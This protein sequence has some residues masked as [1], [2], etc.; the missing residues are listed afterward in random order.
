MAQVHPGALS[1]MLDML[2]QPRLAAIMRATGDVQ[3]Q[4]GIVERDHRR[5]PVTRIGQPIEQLLIRHRIMIDGTKIGHA[6]AGI[7]Q[8]Q[9]QMRARAIICRHDPHRAAQF[10]REHHTV[11]R[12]GVPRPSPAIRRQIGEPQREEPPLPGTSLGHDSTPLAMNDRHCR[13][14]GAKD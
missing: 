4:P 3:R 10:L 8:R 12:C 11:S 2:H 7:G 14:A 1:P 13:R 9:P 5:K 6:R